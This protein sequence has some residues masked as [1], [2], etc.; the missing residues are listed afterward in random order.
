MLKF[1]LQDRE[2]IYRLIAGL[3]GAAFIMAC[4]LIV[5]A[6]FF[7]A[8]LLAIIFA[9]ATWP[10]FN[11][12]NARLQNRTALTAS[13]MTLLLACCFILPLIIIGTSIADNFAKISDA[14]QTSL[15]SSPAATSR[16][17]HNIPY[18][19]EYLGKS[20][21]VLASDQQKLKEAMQQYAAPT[22]QKLIAL[23]G[24]IGR[25]VLDITLGV[26]IAY[27]FF[28]HGTRVAMRTNNLLEKFGG[29]RGRHILDIAKKTLIGVVYGILG[30][31]L[32]QGMLAAI[33]FWIAGVPGAPFLGLMTFFL[34]FI[35]IGPPLIWIPA[36][37]W[38]HSEGHTGW[39]IFLAVWGTAVIGIVDNVLKPYFIYLGSDLPLILVLL[40]V[41]GGV[42]AFGFIGIFIGPTILAVAYSLIIEWSSGRGKYATPVV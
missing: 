29:E 12:L 26:V 35:P 31:A 8:I 18:A 28:R 10:A 5:M 36:A 27:F 3:A 34:S 33:G 22:S 7:P 19:G 40:G 42:L 14:V 4:C 1:D 32:A 11:W 17:L 6:P 9:L 13:I 15:Q 37:L 23:G 20:W 41:I 2:Q 21:D 24:K 16:K 30:T 39:A 38:L 25:G